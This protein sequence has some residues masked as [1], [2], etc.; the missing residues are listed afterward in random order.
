MI[1]QFRSVR[2]P[3]D[4]RKDILHIK[5]T[6]AGQNKITAMD[7]S[8]RIITKIEYNVS[9]MSE[10]LPLNTSEF[11]SGTYFIRVENKNGIS[12]TKYKAIRIS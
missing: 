7:I 12:S 11:K 4:R 3:T 1:V 5:P 6:V 8:G 9:D 10:E 2:T